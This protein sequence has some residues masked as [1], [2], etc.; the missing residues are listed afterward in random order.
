MKAVSKAAAPKRAGGKSEK[1]VLQVRAEQMQAR[2]AERQLAASVA[3]STTQRQPGAAPSLE[4]PKSK[5]QAE[6]ESAPKVTPRP[7]EKP[8]ESAWDDRSHVAAQMKEAGQ[9]ALARYKQRRA[10]DEGQVAAIRQAYDQKHRAEQAAA[11][12]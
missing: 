2:R 6:P 5:A 8:T 12:R 10:E 1:T 11:R 9:A 7:E 3:I 4:L